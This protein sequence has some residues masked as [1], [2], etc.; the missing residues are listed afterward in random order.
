MATTKET[1]LALI[2]GL[3]EVRLYPMMGE[4]VLYCREKAVG[5]IC[6]DKVFVKITPASCAKLGDNAPREIPYAGAQPRFV[7]NADDKAAL[8]ELLFAVADA[9]SAP[10]KKK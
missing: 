4:Y 8:Q 6:D 10:K 1:A 7:V 3:R 9:L 5:C 2:E